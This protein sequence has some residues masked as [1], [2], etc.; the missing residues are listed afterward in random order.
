MAIG[1]KYREKQEY[2]EWL[3]EKAAIKRESPEAKETEQARVARVAELLKPGNECKFFNY[4]FAHLIDCDFAYFHKRDVKELVN[5][6]DF[7]GV[8]EYPREHAKSIIYDV[9]VP[10]LLKARGLLSGMMIASANFDKAAGLLGDLQAELM[11]NKRYIADFGEQYNLGKWKDGHFATT[12]GVGFWAFGRGQSPRGTREAEKRPNYGVWDD[13]DDKGLCKN[14]ERVNETVDWLL[15]DFYG[16]MPIT[17]SKLVG[18]G[19]RIHK[20]SVLAKM[21]GDIE[22]GDPKR[23]GLYHSK[24]FALENKRTHKKDLSPRGVPA[25][26]RYTKLQI[27]EKMKRMGWRRGLREYFHEHIVEG[28]TFKEEHL[29]WADVLP[30][31]E[32][33]LLITYNDPSY[34]NTM[35][36]D[37][38]AIVLIGK[39][40]RYFDIIDC[41]VRQ[42]TTAE[43]VRGHY[44]IASQIPDGLSVKH[45]MEANFIQDLMLEEYYRYGDEN[46]PMLRI[47]GDK[48]KKPDKEVRIENLTPLTEPCYIRFNRQHKQKPD[49]IELRYQFLGFP[50][51][52]VH[53]DGPDAVEGAVYILDKK[54]GRKQKSGRT[55]TGKY[56]HKQGRSAYY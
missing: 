8:M 11:F 30:L 3:K 34:K 39:V 38:K 12:D 10:M 22:E 26:N 7:F 16:A 17:G 46:P 27:T 56:S 32:Y 51:K 18:V 1:G 21:V 9:M 54:K 37:F 36:S 20:K 4:Y 43:M 55:R 23:E 48:R 45:Y 5:T 19:N 53:D 24:V 29:P 50:A 33:D 2:D 41:F 6:H 44:E 47:R 14:E 13:I 49:M 42:C 31:K 25:W 35:T 28:K 40:G 52:G 15:E